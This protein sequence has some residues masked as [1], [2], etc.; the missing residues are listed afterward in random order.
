MHR[1]YFYGLLVFTAVVAALV[2][3]LDGEKMDEVSVLSVR[4][5]EPAPSSSLDPALTPE[6]RANPTKAQFVEHDRA[7]FD[8]LATT[9][10]P[11]TTTTTLPATSTAAP[12]TTEPPAEQPAEIQPKNAA[13]PQPE[14]SGGFN[15]GFESDF[16]SAINS[17]RSSQGLAGLSRDGSLDAEARA[18]AKR[19]AELG[20]LSHS[21]IGRFIP[22]WSAA[23]ENV[24][25]GGSVSS[26][27]DSFAASAGHRSNILG[28]YTHF[29]IGV[30]VDGSGGLWTAHVFTG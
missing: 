12:A 29:G 21:N 20:D 3:L 5:P 30:W 28:G 4:F 9:T 1:S 18:W 16:A 7:L 13:P 27:F 6:P 19:M 14:V 15:A 10:P 22:P 17:L 23:G 25:R 24:G 2:G 8:R 26:L 11:P